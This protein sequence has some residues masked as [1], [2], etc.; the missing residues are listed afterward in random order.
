LIKRSKKTGINEPEYEFDSNYCSE[1]V[2][3]IIFA[4]DGYG[5][6][7]ASDYNLLIH[8]PMIFC[9]QSQ[10]DC[11]GLKTGDTVLGNVSSTKEGE[12]YFPLIKVN[13]IK[14]YRSQVVRI[15]FLVSNLTTFIPQRKI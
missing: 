3:D 8:L 10:L 14:R 9:S 6:L 1:G 5:F 11:F 4:K 12:E 13:K 15:E 2:L 7:R